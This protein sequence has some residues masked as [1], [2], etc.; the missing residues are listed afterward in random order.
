MAIS[1]VSGQRDAEAWATAATKT[2]TLASAPTS[3]NLLVIRFVS[4]VIPTTPTNWNRPSAYSGGSSDTSLF[5]KISDGTETSVTLTAA[6]QTVAVYDEWTGNI[7]SSIANCR[8]QT[9]T[10]TNSTGTG[11]TGTTAQADELALAVLGAGASSSGAFSAWTNSFT[12]TND[13]QSPAGPGSEVT[14]GFA[15][16]ILTATGTYSTAATNAAANSVRSGQITTFKAA[17]AAQD[18][19]RQR[20]LAS[21]LVAVHR[22]AGW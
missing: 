20:R 15:E 6:G 11:T 1:L 8:D 3:G 19:Y 22:A 21:G 4:D 2:L 12:E 16:L 5:C 17:A 9:A 18:G 14:G 10:A 7:S 13:L